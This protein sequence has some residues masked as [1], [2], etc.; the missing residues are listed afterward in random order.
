MEY[1]KDYREQFHDLLM[2]FGTIGKHT[3][4]KHAGDDN[5]FLSAEGLLFKVFDLGCTTLNLLESGPMCSNLSAKYNPLSAINV[6][7]RAA[8]EAFLIFNY[9]FI[10]KPSKEENDLRYWIWKR[11]SLE[12]W[13]DYP[14]NTRKRKEDLKSIDADIA[15]ADQHINENPIFT[16]LSP[17]K[18]EKRLSK[19]SWLPKYKKLGK[20]AGVPLAI[21]K[22]LYNYL[23][24]FA[25]SSYRSI[26]TSRDTEYT[27]NNIS[28][29]R[30]P[31]LLIMYSIA[32]SIVK[33]L[34]LWN[35]D[36]E[37][38]PESQ[39]SAVMQVFEQH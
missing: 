25:H 36:V 8:Y 14:T 18:K 31:I 37:I 22:D 30:V 2:A 11:I 21:R 1:E 32:M 6:I 38:L 16:K 20:K 7:A 5:R 13:R 9:V 10:D 27:I 39:K 28:Y 4:G 19:I 15:E 34:E 33:Y 29:L 23:C 24:G 17:E 35:L 12:E 26:I 3:K